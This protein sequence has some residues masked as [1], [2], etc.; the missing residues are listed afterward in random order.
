MALAH[1][2]RGFTEN[3]EVYY[4]S[5]RKLGMGTVDL[6]ELTPKTVTIAGAGIAGEMN[7]PSSTML[8]N[9]E[10]TIHWRTIHND[11]TL[12]NEPK[13][14]SLTLR[15]AQRNY[16]SASGKFKIQAVKIDLRGVPSK[17][18]LGKFEQSSETES[19]STLTLDYLK[20]TVDNTVKVEFDRFN[21][22]YKVD[23]TDYLA[24]IKTALGLS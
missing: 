9:M 17:M 7:F 11:L 1:V 19:E 4:G 22:I 2:L 8:E 20:L 16:D 23:G 10:V 14:H 24:G 18:T 21:Y 3:F 13:A 5:T 15:S 6:P 12:L